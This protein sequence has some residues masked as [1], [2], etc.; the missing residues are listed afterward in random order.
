MKT[1]RGNKKNVQK[2]VYTNEKVIGFDF[3]LEIWFNEDFLRD[4]IKNYIIKKILPAL[5][6]VKPL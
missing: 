2:K 6:M 1:T 4:E 5:K 3:F